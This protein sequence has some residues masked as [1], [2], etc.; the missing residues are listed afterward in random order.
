MSSSE[1]S[2]TQG[3]ES[4]SAPVQAFLGLGSNLGDS[5]QLLTD[6]L[7][8]LSDSL[9]SHSPST[10][11][12]T[13]VS[14]IYRSEAI[15]G[16]D[17]SPD[18]LNLVAQ[19]QTEM[20]PHELLAICQQAEQRAE[21]VRAEHWGPRTL[22]VDVLLY[23]DLRLADADLIIPH[24]RMF[25]RQFVIEPLAELAPGLVRVLLAEFDPQ[26]REALENE[27]VKQDCYKIAQAPWQPAS[28]AA[29]ST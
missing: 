13:A 29:R 17:D 25:E 26:T 16:P 1:A 3:R 23:G 20:T 28:V 2:P 22:D 10:A 15:G 9:V 24:P 5:Q 12:I 18:F 21:R 7:Q 11:D 19:L 8:F 14:S 27:R 4:A 6:A